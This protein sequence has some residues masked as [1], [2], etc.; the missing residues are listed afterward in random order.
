MNH[1]PVNSI[2]AQDFLVTVSASDHV[3]LTAGVTVTVQVINPTLTQ[4]L[5]GNP[6]SR[7]IDVSSSG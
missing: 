4:W 7:G 1:V 2:P 5:I 3:A 6:D